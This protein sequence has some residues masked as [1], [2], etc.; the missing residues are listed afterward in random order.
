M[1]PSESE[2]T[3]GALALLRNAG[4]KRRLRQS[5]GEDEPEPGVRRAF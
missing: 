1:V 2:F 3:R 5:D 4:A